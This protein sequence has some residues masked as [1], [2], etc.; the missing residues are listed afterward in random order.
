MSRRDRASWSG[1]AADGGSSWIWVSIDCGIWGSRS[2]CSRCV[3]PGS[4]AEFPALRSL[5]AFPSNLPLQVTSFVGRDDELG[6]IAKVFDDAR[7]VT[8]DR[9]GWGGQD[10]SRVAGGGGAVA[11]FRRRRV[12]V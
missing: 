9:C 5:E 11:A 4:A 3:H 12:V 2:M 10:P 6:E 1:T 7:V 8:L